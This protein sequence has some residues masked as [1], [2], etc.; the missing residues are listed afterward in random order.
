MLYRIQTLYLFISI[1][2]YSVFI[3]F[4]YSFNINKKNLAYFFYLNSYFKN[5]IIIFIIICLFLS[6]LSFLFFKKK[7]LQIYLNKINILVNILVLILFF[8]YSYYHT[9]YSI[10]ILFPM[11]LCIYILWISNIAIKKDIELIDSINR[12]R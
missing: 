12:I 3:Y 5:I 9:L 11:I 2:I 1:F 10:I 6:I 7:K 4:L 8:S